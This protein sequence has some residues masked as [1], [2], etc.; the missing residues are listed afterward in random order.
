MAFKPSKKLFI[1]KN[2]WNCETS[3]ATLVLQEEKILEYEY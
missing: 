3:C 1:E 2:I